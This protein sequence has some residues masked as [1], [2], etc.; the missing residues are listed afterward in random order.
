M[1]ADCDQCGK[2]THVFW[3]DTVGKFIISGC[4]NHSRT[5]FDISHNSRGYDAVFTAQVFGSELE[6][7]INNGWYQNFKYDCRASALFGL[8]EFST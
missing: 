8:V 2:R 4:L 3:L 6:A 7:R 5:R 1:N